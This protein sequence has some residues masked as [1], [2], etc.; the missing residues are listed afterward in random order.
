MVVTEGEFIAFVAEVFGLS[1]EKLLLETTYGSLPEWD[2]MAQLR[3]VMG[4][5]AKYGVEIPFADVVNV[6]SLWEF[7]RRINGGPVKKV[8]A[9]DLDNTLWEGVVGED[10]LDAIHPNVALQRELKALKERGIL[11][12]ILSKNNEEDGLAGL[13]RQPILKRED[14]V[15]WRIDWQPK[16]ENLAHLAAELNLG[17]DSF[18]FIDDNPSE[19]LEMSVRLP[20]VTALD[21]GANLAAY[22]PARPLTDED[23][24]KTDEYR[25]EAKRSACL[26]ERRDADVWTTLGIELDVHQMRESEVPR[27][28]QL[29]QKA[30]QF[31]VCTN[32][33]SEEA[34]RRLAEE[35]LIITAHAKDRFGDQGLVAFVVVRGTEIVDWVMSCRVMGR[36]IEDRVEAELERLMSLRGV[37]ELTAVWRASGK[38]IPVRNLYDRFGF[39]LVCETENERHY[40]RTLQQQECAS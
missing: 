11:L 14:F 31:D 10:G 25:A 39:T 35:G 29:S 9:V 22:F 23:L 4:V 12:V 15:A 21:V 13:D 40:R 32:R 28:A 5:A 37:S 3:L 17:A 30:N 27:V 16:A 6:T 7:L 2:S 24:R 18:V 20:D 1:P 38:N 33:Y 8:V 19:R 34:I 26:A 36:G